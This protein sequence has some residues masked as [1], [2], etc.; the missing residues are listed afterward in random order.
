MHNLAAIV[1]TL[2]IATF[3]T[4]TTAKSWILDIQPLFQKRSVRVLHQS[5]SP[6]V[7]TR[8]NRWFQKPE[9]HRDMLATA[10]EQRLTSTAYPVNVTQS[11][12]GSVKTASWMDR[13]MKRVVSLLTYFAI[14]QGII[15][16]LQANRSEIAA[17]VSLTMV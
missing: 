8:K 10:K 5:S 17:E 3:A 15:H 4:Y 1:T 6:M 11:T 2:V 14:G 13:T 16:F 9:S 7:A 12:S